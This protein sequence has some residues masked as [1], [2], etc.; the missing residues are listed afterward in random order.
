MQP[1][2]VIL[3]SPA[4]PSGASW[5]L[6]CLLELDVKTGHKPC[7]DALWR[8]VNPQARPD[9]IWQAT[10]SGHRLDPRAGVL[11]KWLPAVR[12][13][14][15]FAFRTDVEVDY[16]QDPPAAASDAERAAFFVRDP[17]DAFHSMYRRVTPAVSFEAFLGAPHPR[18]LLDRVDHWRLLVESW[19][20]PSTAFV[21][22][23]DY[24]RDATATLEAAL[25]AMEIDAEPAAIERAVRESS[26]EKAAEAEKTYREAHPGDGERI[27]RRGAI[28]DWRSGERVATEAF[29]SIEAR[30]GE[31]LH[32]FGYE[33]SAAVAARG[34]N[35]L[36]ELS[37]YIEWY[38][39]WDLSAVAG[40]T[41]G[42]ADRGPL[43]TALAFAR[44]VEDELLVGSRLRPDEVATLLGSLIE[45][46]EKRGER[47]DDRLRSMYARF[48][49][50]GPRH[51][52][53]ILELKLER[54]RRR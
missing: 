2:R 21:R 52:E 27:N 53:H 18:S 43:A 47:V 6:N 41:E 10:D 19:T 23:E 9:A 4:E 14:R 13:P 46:L 31:L 38:R 30:A 5:L 15:V 36:L 22:F 32:R 25:S 16:V 3:A 49:P 40:Q 8:N 39:A 1:R 20:R 34:R 29:A 17:R 33:G 45:L 28:G 42:V 54:R 51:L 35:A 37:P 11:R 50:G 7:V 44:L 24:K 12:N 26:F 48:E